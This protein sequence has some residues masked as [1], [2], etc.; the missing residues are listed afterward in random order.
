LEPDILILL[1]RIAF[2]VLLYLF[3]FLI[4]I[5]GYRQVKTSPAHP[6]SV[7]IPTAKTP[8]VEPKQGG[9]GNLLVLEAGEDGLPIGQNFALQPVTTLGRSAL[10]AIVI[11]DSFASS[12]HAILSWRE[13]AW[14]LEDA[15]STN[16]TLLNRNIV[17]KPTVV[18]NG[19]IIQ[20]GR[21]KLKIIL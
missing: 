1:L 13:Q 20:I 19:D 8:T 3:I 14:W 4:A 6:R 10:N 16:G 18:K 2:A 5:V 17:Q 7:A 12:E 9:S 11:P 15:G 21:V